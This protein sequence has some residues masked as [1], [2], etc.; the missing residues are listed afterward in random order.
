MP[1]FLQVDQIASETLQARTGKA[2]CP[3]NMEI[4]LE[5]F[6]LNP[7]T[8]HSTRRAWPKTCYNII[9]LAGLRTR[10]GHQDGGLSHA[11]LRPGAGDQTQSVRHASSGARR[12]VAMTAEDGPRLVRLP[13]CCGESSNATAET[14]LKP[15]RS[16]GKAA[17]GRSL[18]LEFL[19]I[20]QQRRRQA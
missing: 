18:Q 16:P 19:Q 7:T 1:T 15:R 9:F 4:T 10:S 5:S 13:A 11:P 8:K 12:R 17:I 14:L 20:N 3:E 2:L 6:P